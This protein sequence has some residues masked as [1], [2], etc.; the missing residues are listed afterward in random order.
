MLRE[1]ITAAAGPPGVVPGPPAHTQVETFSAAFAP[2]TWDDGDSTVDCVFYSGAIVP[3]VD[4]WTGEPYDLVLSLEPGAIRMDRL[5]NG[6][7]VVDNHNTF[8][9]IRDQLGVVKPGTARVE[10]GNHTVV[11]TVASGTCLFDYLQAAVL[12]DPVAPAMTYSNVSAAADFDTDQT[13][14]I[15]PARVLWNYQQLGLFGDLDFYAGVFF[16]LKRVRNG[17][18]FHSATVTLTG[19]F[20]SGSGFGEGDVFWLDISGTSLGAAMYPADSPDGSTLAQRLIDAVNGTFVGIHAA[21]ASTPGQFTVTSLSPINGFTMNVSAG[22]GSTGSIAMTGD[23]GAGN[24]G[25]WQ[26]D[27]SQ[28]SPLNRAFQDY[29]ADLCA[30]WHAAGMTLTVAFS[31]EL[32]APPDANTAAGA[33]TQRFADGTQVLTATG[34]GTWGAGFVEAASGSTIQETGHGYITGNTWHA[35]G[36]SGSGAWLITVL[37]ADHFSLTTEVSNSGGYTPAVGDATY[38]ELQTSQCCFNP[39]TVTAFL[40]ACYVQ[41]ASIMSAAGLTPWLQFGEVLWWFFNWCTNTSDGQ[42]IEAGMAY[43]DANTSAAAQAALGRALAMFSH[44]TD[45]PSINGY[46]DANF[47]RARIK[48][49]ID[50]IRV[51]VLAV[52]PGAQF[53]LLWPYDVN[54]PTQNAYGVGG[55]LNR[56]VNLPIEYQQQSGSGLNRLKMEALSFGSQERNFAKAYEAMTFP[57]TAP[58]AWTR[59]TSAYLIPWFN[60]GCPWDREWLAVSD[61]AVNPS[62]IGFWAIDHLCSFGWPLPLPVRHSTFQIQ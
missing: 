57:W 42:H 45:D 58:M 41:A 52:V 61:A 49:H 3:R 27:A 54:Y 5:N 13:Y 59:A 2:D 43:Y 37:D 1:N 19:P 29:L 62:W 35:A 26:V 20:G 60:G 33:W 24:E 50:G 22:S 12:S 15:P 47:L 21:P 18:S 53:E 16:A 51:A 11:L 10:K 56:Y 46:A 34:F 7:P 40:A 36:A 32:L 39:A 14:K 4:F 31:Q 6:A 55:Q 17:G 38:I 8:G 30:L 9:S 48:A 28:A 23:I 25:T 44:A